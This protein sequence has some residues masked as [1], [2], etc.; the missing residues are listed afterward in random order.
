MA[1]LLNFGGPIRTLASRENPYPSVGIIINA[2]SA[3][4]LSFSSCS[5]AIAY[6]PGL[7]PLKLNVTC[8]PAG[9]TTLCAFASP[10]HFGNR[11]G[12]VVIQAR[13]TPSLERSS[14]AVTVT[15]VPLAGALA[16]TKKAAP[17]AP[18]TART[19]WICP[20]RFCTADPKTGNRVRNCMYKPHDGADDDWQLS[21]S[22]PTGNEQ[23]RAETFPSPY[24][25]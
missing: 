2:R 12:L 14:V 21:A 19:R 1:A 3:L 24:D 11:L 16:L 18:V 17:A 10:R 20:N 5:S 22:F 15:V 4:P 8:L 13:T 6:R 7:T 25:W 23:G 9:T